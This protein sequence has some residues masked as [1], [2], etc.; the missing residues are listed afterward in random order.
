MRKESKND[1]EIESQETSENAVEKKVSSPR[2]RSKVK[3]KV[4]AEKTIAEKSTKNSKEATDLA[5]K[6]SEVKSKIK[7]KPIE[8]KK[9]A[10]ANKDKVKTSGLQNK[11][12][13]KPREEAVSLQDTISKV[14]DVVV[15]EVTNRVKKEPTQKRTRS[16]IKSKSVEAKTTDKNPIKTESKVESKK[17]S[18]K[19]IVKKVDKTEITN[20][21]TY[22]FHQGKNYEAYN[23]MGSHIKTEKRKKG[24][25]FS[26]W[27]PNAKEV[28]V[29]GDFNNFEISEEFKLSKI[30]ENGIWS[31]F[32][33]G[34]NQGTKYKYCIISKDG[35]KGEYKS[36]PYAIQSEVRPNNA[37]IVY[38]PLKFKWSDRKWINKRNKV[39]CLEQPINIYEV[40]LGSWKKNEDGEFLTYEEIGEKLPDYLKEMGYTHVEFM[41]LVEH[42]LDASWGYQGTGYYSPTSRYGNIEGLK[43]LINKL[44]SEDIGVIMDWAPGHFCKDSNGLYRF[45]G[46]PLYEYEEEWRAENKGWGTCNFDL[47]RPEV[48][49]YLISNALYWYREFHIDGIRVDAV[50]SILYLDYSRGFGEWVPNKFGG[51]G[52]L[53]AIEFLKELNQAVF[54]EYPTALMIA[55]ESTA[56]P[57]VTKPPIHDGLGFNFKWNMGWMNDTLEY[58]EID[59]KYRK[60]NHKNITF[61]MMY[62][63]AEN[64]MLPVSHDE[65]VHGKKSLIEKMWGDEWNK[66][67]GLRAYIGYMM[68]HPGKKLLFMGSEFAQSIEWREYEELKWN[69]IEESDFNKQT[70]LFFKDM[71]KFYLENKALWELDYDNKGF[72]WIEADNSNQSILIFARRSRSDEDTLIFVINFTSEVYYDYKIG[73]PFLGEYEETFNTDESKYGGSGQVMDT[74]LIAEKEPFQKQPY[75]I[76]IKVPPMATLVLKVNQIKN[77][78]INAVKEIKM[79][80]I[81][82]FSSERNKS[83]NE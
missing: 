18:T 6:K 62:N 60:D 81:D 3:A 31:G 38:E 44:H 8:V 28:Y 33:P 49:S 13:D 45:D 24:V 58:V 59:P 30:S 56:W 47:G 21:N 12:E 78:E 50:S 27:A 79:K 23:I 72:N 76:K 71:N 55:E 2:S 42:P 83:V 66:F 54:A 63:Y 34:I 51:N 15:K 39:N 36:D 61:S 20:F 64:Y 25:Q 70:Q 48:R 7:E 9:K 32:F 74:V 77:E 26:T 69:E 16:I 11:K 35:I 80:E 1:T 43:T 19:R 46:S 53:E 22:L 73:V 57:N 40:H 68:G 41:P 52:N 14:K 65:V 17:T 4:E 5:I 29:V 37:S 75:S 67:A 10:T 82:N